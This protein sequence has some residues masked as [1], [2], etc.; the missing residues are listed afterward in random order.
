MFGSKVSAIGL[1]PKRLTLKNESRLNQQPPNAKT[2][3][4]YLRFSNENLFTALRPP[5][6][7]RLMSFLFE[8]R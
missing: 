7:R 2:A 8:G 4:T 3:R 1:S 6:R 5:L